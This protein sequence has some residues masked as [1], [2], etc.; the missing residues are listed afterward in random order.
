M[1]NRWRTLGQCVQACSHHN[2]VTAATAPTSALAHV[3]GPTNEPDVN[4]SDLR[5]RRRQRRLDSLCMVRRVAGPLVVTHV[6]KS[7]YLSLSC[8]HV[9]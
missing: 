8:C 7:L 5:F 1:F 2:I 6:D 4:M 3:S 9:A